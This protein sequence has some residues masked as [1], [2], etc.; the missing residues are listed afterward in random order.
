MKSSS[1][2]GMGIDYIK[3]TQVT[4]DFQLVAESIQ[5]RK[6]EGGNNTGSINGY[7]N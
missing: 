5:P 2:T 6:M 3:G 7:Q 4:K 1:N